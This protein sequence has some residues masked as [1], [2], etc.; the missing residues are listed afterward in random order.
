MPILAPKMYI[1]SPKMYLLV[2][3]FS[4]LKRYSPSDGFSTFFLRVHVFLGKKVSIKSGLVFC[5]TKVKPGLDV[6]VSKQL[7]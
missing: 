2:Q 6:L 4:L 7:F 5:F 3:K 1:L